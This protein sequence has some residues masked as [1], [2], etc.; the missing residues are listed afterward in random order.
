MVPGLKKP[1]AFEHLASTVIQLMLR[2]CVSK[3]WVLYCLG[4]NDLILIPAGAMSITFKEVSPGNNYLGKSTIGVMHHSVVTF[5]VR[6]NLVPK[7]AI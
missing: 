2:I 7:T 1:K 3:I 5:C 4:Y 6:T